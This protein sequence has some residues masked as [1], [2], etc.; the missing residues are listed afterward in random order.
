[1][2]PIVID[3][4]TDSSGDGS[5]EGRPI[6]GWLYELRYDKG[7]FAA[8]VDCTVSFTDEKDDSITLL[9]LTDANSSDNYFPREVEHDN[10][11]SAQSTLALPV[12]VGIPKV[13]IASGGDTKS[14]HVILYMME[15]G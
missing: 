14:G 13:V 9:T 11:G 10:A 2:E 8:G 15:D 12:I 3:I 7:D 1:M 6:N 5:A 4:T